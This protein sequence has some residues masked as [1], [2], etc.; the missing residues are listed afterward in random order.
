M[1]FLSIIILGL[2]FI[3]INVNPQ[4]SKPD[5]TQNSEILKKFSKLSEQ[6]LVDTAEYY[7]ENYLSD[8]ALIL[9]NYIINTQVKGNDIEQQKMKIKVY[10]NSALI[11]AQ[12]NDYRTAY[13]YYI[14]ALDLSEKYNFHSYKYRIYKNIG[15]IYNCFEKYDIAKS[16]YLI[17]LSLC[18]DSV[19]IAGLLTN[20]GNIET[21][22]GQL[23]S[24]FYYYN[25]SLRASKNN[26]NAYL[27]VILQN[28]AFYYNNQKQNDSV[29]H[30]LRLS[31]IESEKNNNIQNKAM[32]FS[33]FGNL[34][35]ETQKIDSALF[36][37]NLSNAIAKE[38]NFKDILQTN[39]HLLSEIEESKGNMKN[40]LDYYKTYVH[41]K[42]SL[43]NA[44]KFGEITQL[45]RLYEVSKT[46]QQIEQL[47]I[48]QQV[49]ERTI[50]LQRIIWI[51]TSVILLL[52]CILLI[53][54]YLQKRK[55]NRAY[56]VL[57][58]KNV[59]IMELYENSGEKYCE[60]YK[61]RYITD[62]FQKNLLNKITGSISNIVGKF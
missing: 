24:A 51:G 18:E 55:L 27:E 34:F 16:Y 47:I 57:Y 6:Q 32:I 15:N 36:Y 11:Y 58:K 1:K 7:R 12:M 41:L 2:F 3:T 25:Q 35:F 26:N 29:F 43:F 44:Q 17:A 22:L 10:N 52:V 46:N 38:N 45:Q 56:K 37:I 20:M 14:K 8:T 23:D 31:L 48:N 19:L 9:Y 4:D 13:D 49:K 33:N 62:D 59:E 21:R 42:D 39:Y 5:V 61:N 60:K 53:F 54:I 50:F 28:L 30:Y 40:S